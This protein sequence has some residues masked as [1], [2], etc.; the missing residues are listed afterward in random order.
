MGVAE[1]S[2]FAATDKALLKARR[3]FSS[4]WFGAARERNID[5]LKGIRLVLHVN[6]GA[7]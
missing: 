6:G 7:V 3:W 5:N 2:R 1:G 4:V